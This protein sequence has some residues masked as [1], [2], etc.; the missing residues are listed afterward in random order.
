MTPRIAIVSDPLV[1]RGGAEKCVEAL[2]EAFPDAPVYAVLYS[3]R[4]GPEQ[5][6]ARVTSSWLGKLPQ[7]ERRHRLLLPLYRA[8]IESF[9]LSAYDVIVSSHHSVGKNLLRRA[10]QVHVCYCH[11]PMRALW[12]RPFDEVRTQPAP[13]RPLVHH[14]LSSLR[15]W[16]YTGAARVDAFVANSETTRLRIAKHYGR[17]SVVVNPPIDVDRFTPGGAVGD[18]YLVASRH[19]PYK[20]VD[21]AVA[22]A[23]R[24]GRRLIVVGAGARA[25]ELR[26]PGVEILG[27]VEDAK[28]LA[29]MRSARAL[30]FPGL[31]DFGMTP[32][33]MMAC[34][35]PVIAYDAGG[36]K[37]TVVDGVNGVLVPE[38]SVDAFVAGIERCEAMT[39]DPA[40]IRRSA[41]GFSRPRYI[42]AMRRIVAEQWDRRGCSEPPPR[43]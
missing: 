27:H 15:V 30:L 35:R 5:L 32:V 6:A 37:E 11:T 40:Q 34:G 38:Q 43:S 7:A 39:F 31:E 36:A 3:A 33:E 24:A 25:R 10:E 42:E 16:D 12:E 8:A 19:V 17:D 13:L 41:E 1:Q 29:L 21:L 23:A 22:A 9:D 20:R 4:Y 14:L 28:L 18:Y 26:A 2:A